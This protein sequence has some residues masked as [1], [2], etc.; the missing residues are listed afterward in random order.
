MPNTPYPQIC[1]LCGFGKEKGPLEY[2]GKGVFVHFET[3][4]QKERP[5]KPKEKK[6]LQD[7]T[8]PQCI[9]IARQRYLDDC[10]YNAPT[11]FRESVV[12][13]RSSEEIF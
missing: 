9:C 10:P 3:C 6:P 13:R 11:P 2:E 1:R 4:E 12:A 8:V 5:R 7:I